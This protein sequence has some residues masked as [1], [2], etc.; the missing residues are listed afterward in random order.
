MHLSAILR[1]VEGERAK[2]ASVFLEQS[3]MRFRLKYVLGDYQE[4]NTE[5]AG[6]EDPY[7]EEDLEAEEDSPD[8]SSSVSASEAALLSE[9]LGSFLDRVEAIAKRYHDQVVAAHGP[10]SSLDPDDKNAALDL[11]QT[12]AEDSDEYVELVSDIVDELRTKFSIVTLGRYEKSPTGWPKA[13]SIKR[14]EGERR[15]FLNAVRF[16][17]GV[18]VRSWGKLLARQR[19][20]RRRPLR[21]EVGRQA[22]TSRPDGH[23]GALAQGERQCR[24]TRTHDRPL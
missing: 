4:E 6:D 9:R 10:L 21:C 2:M 1:A 19:N 17:W 13:W 16:F 14:P 8:E 23:R 22:A 15:E 24:P 7:A 18:W 5:G 3:D 20:P 11:I 12:E